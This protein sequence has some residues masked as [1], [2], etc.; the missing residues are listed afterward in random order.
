MERFVLVAEKQSL[1]LNLY[2]K[3][4]IAFT[5]SRQSSRGVRLPRQQAVHVVLAIADLPQV[6]DSVVLWVAVDVVNHRGE[7]TVI[8]YPYNLMQLYGIELTDI[9]EV[10]TTT[11]WTF[12]VIV[13]DEFHHLFIGHTVN[14]GIWEFTFN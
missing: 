8:Q 13:S 12:D 5:D 9:S 14:I 1:T 3:A 10:L 4:I 7:R 2:L 11:V 6:L